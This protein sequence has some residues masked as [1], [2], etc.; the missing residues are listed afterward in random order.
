MSTNADGP[1]LKQNLIKKHYHKHRISV[2]GYINMATSS[3]FQH[4]FPTSISHISKI[5]AR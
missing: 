3:G 2:Q 5:V 1:R 4:I